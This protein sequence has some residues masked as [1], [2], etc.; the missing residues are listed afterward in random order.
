MLISSLYFSLKCSTSCSSVMSPS[1]SKRSHSVYSVSRY[2]A[3]MERQLRQGW[4]RIERRT[5]ILGAAI[6][7]EKAKNGRARLQNE[8]LYR[9][10]AS[11]PRFFSSRSCGGTHQ[12]R[13]AE[14]TLATTHLV[15]LDADETS[16]DGSGWSTRSE[17]ATKCDGI[18][19]EGRTGRERRDDLAGDTL[20]A[21]PV[22]GLNAVVL[23]AQV[24]CVGGNW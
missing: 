5:F 21:V 6:G 9:S 1:I 2:C 7:S 8:F 12:P 22:G 4:T 24:G 11:A 16:D 19:R 23:C 14:G 10:R 18:A 15:E 20:R 17:S 13:S 3:E